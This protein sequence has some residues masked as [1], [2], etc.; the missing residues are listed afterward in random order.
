MNQS[1][2]PTLTAS[3]RRLNQLKLAILWLVPV[4]LMAI[5]GVYYYLVQTGI[6]TIGSKNNGVL[7]Q[8][9]VQTAELF[10]DSPALD[11]GENKTVFSGKWSMVIPG[12]VD[13][14][15][16]C[17]E[18]L[19]LT[20]QLHIRLDKEANRV[21][22]IY[23][24]PASLV[25]GSGEPGMLPADFAAFL[26]KE[27]HYLKPLPVQPGSLEQLAARI[28]AESGERA[29]FF[30]V[31]PRGW[32]MMYYLEEHDGNAILADLK[33]LLKYSRER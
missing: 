14:D 7:I 22:R 24:Y 20:R 30:L 16:G 13:C 2:P 15:A 21:Q 8:P 11:A 9:P 6:V 27:H 17:R 28:T 33:H 3:Q 26:E 23:L 19:H 5:A 25:S 12:D 29:G 4:G 31:D 10:K 32:A 18:A 1:A